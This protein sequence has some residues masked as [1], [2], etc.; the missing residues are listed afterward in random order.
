MI[1]KST[2]EKMK[3]ENFFAEFL[4]S[5]IF[6]QI[7]CLVI[8]LLSI[9]FRSL[10]DIGADTGVYLSIGAKVAKGGKYYYDFFESNFPISFYFYALQYQLSQMLHLNPIIMSEICINLFAVLSILLSAKILK[11][12][13]IY[14]NKAHYNLILVSF[15]IGF[16]L[17]PYALEIGE[18]GTKTSLL[19]ILLFPYIAFSFG[20]KTGFTRNEL[21]LRGCLMG[22][23]PCVK[24]H[25]IIFILFIEFYKFSQKKSLKFFLELDKLVMGLV[26]VVYL[27]LMLKFT[28]EF[29]EFMTPMWSQTYSAYNNPKIFFENSLRHVASRAT[30]FGFIFLIFSRHKFSADDKILALFFAAASTLMLIENIGTVDQIVTFYA[31]ATTCFLKFLFD[32]FASKKFSIADNLF[33]TSTLIFLPIFDLEIF[34]SSIF[35]LGGF[36]NIWWLVILIYP[37]LLIKKFGLE[38]FQEYLTRRN[39]LIFFT[40]Y[41]L[42]L[43][44]VILALKYVSGWAYIALNLSLLFVVLFFFE[45]KIYAKFFPT[46]SPFFIFVVVTSV[47][48]LLYAYVT[49][50]VGLIKHDN[51]YIYPN[52]ISDFMTYYSKIHAP[53]KE[54]GIV[55]VSIWIA[56]QF[57]LVNY[58]GKDGYHK[59]HIAA[60]QANKAVMGSKL[61]FPIQDRDQ[62][63]T[64]AYLF[65]DLKN[66]ME[67]PHVKVLFVNNSRQIMDKDNR[68]L[69]G[70]LEYY[71]AD[72]K[73]KKLFFE[74]FHFEN[75]VILTKKIKPLKKV[76][77]ITKEEASIFDQ[78]KPTTVKIDHDFE[79]YVRNEKN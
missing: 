50:A 70:A 23:I 49:T 58:L 19:L 24:P 73:F 10:I 43:L 5:R 59:F 25:Y 74:N 15:F 3:S 68:C 34:P 33:I 26:G 41:S 11:S 9:F 53:Q 39:I 72:P 79:V 60:I 52:K 48:C 76:R 62:V 28:P 35:G 69:I 30:V 44:T 51:E 27:F 16:F 6:L 66:Q 2:L 54:D 14:Q 32:L 78:A 65:D 67:N 31:I 75:R 45:R 64:F 8:L 1:L 47:S 36:V 21:I 40:T 56:H 71:L 46:F 42:L 37:W 17:R 18:F 12:S 13:G 7:S 55:V 4:G 29:F 61:M 22:L 57:P 77:F 38:K 20:R 63:F